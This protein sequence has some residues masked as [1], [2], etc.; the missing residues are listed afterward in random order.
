MRVVLSHLGRGDPCVAE[1]AF[2][3]EEALGL[4][5]DVL[6]EGGASR[7]RSSEDETLDHDSERSTAAVTG[8]G[9][10]AASLTISPGLRIPSKPSRMVLG[11]GAKG[12]TLRRTRGSVTWRGV[13]G[14]R[15][16]ERAGGSPE[17]PDQ[18]DDGHD[19]LLL[20]G[21]REGA[22]VHLETRGRREA[23]S[24]CGTS[25]A[26]AGAGGTRG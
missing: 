15:K 17:E 26:R 19:E 25:Q 18:I 3:A 16:R 12:W 22:D 5:G 24:M 21:I 7:A 2:D 23:V 11:L 1:V 4:V 14:W 13:K 20:D 9:G 6:Q 8:A 10:D